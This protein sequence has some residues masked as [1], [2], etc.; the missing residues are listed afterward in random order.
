LEGGRM[1]SSIEEKIGATPASMERSIV[2]LPGFLFVIAAA[3]ETLSML[4]MTVYRYHNQAM[5]PRLLDLTETSNVLGL[6][7]AMP[8]I[9]LFLMLAA[10][11]R[12][13]RIDLA[14]TAGAVACGGI[15]LLTAAPM[16]PADKRDYLYVLYLLVKAIELAFFVVALQPRRRK[17]WRAALSVLGY[18]LFFLLAVFTIVIGAVLVSPVESSAI[19]Q[20]SPQEFDAAVILGA[21][22]YRGNKPS[23]VL[24]ERI[25]K[26]YD[27]LK[28]GTV[29][30]LVLTGGNAPNELPEAEVARRE[31][32]KRGVDPT[33]IVME[34][35]T[36][37]T[38]QQ[39][40]YI[41]DQLSKQGWSSFLI[42][43]DQFHLKRVL[44][45]CDFNDINAQGVSSESPLGPQNLAIYHLRES[46]ALIL[47]WMFGA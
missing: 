7:L 6:L 42:V 37:S 43:S 14:A 47:Y 45:I 25:N 27:L 31:L 30:F 38:V 46:V 20:E 19:S 18:T 10:L 41:R 26:G 28:E 12:F 33:R 24:R 44:E 5:A 9:L 3:G 15:V 35:H 40:I 11:P 36:S 4:L 16:L 8:F 22:V 32:L 13:R 21:A 23:P 34:T 1:E 39:V 2:W 29:Q 17:P